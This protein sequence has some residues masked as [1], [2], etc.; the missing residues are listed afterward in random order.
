MS[1]E[2]YPNM[3][4]KS[5]RVS[6]KGRFLCSDMEAVGLLDA[7]R[8]NDPTCLHTF[9]I[10]DMFT[11][12]KFLFFDPYEKRMEHSRLA[13]EHDGHQDGYL[14]DAIQMLMEAEAICFQ[15]GVGYDMLAL[16][17]VYPNDWKFN[18][19]EARGKDREHSA[20]FPR[21]L[22]DTMIISQLLNP[23]RRA[24]PQAFALGR[25]NVGPHSI[26]AHGI[27]IGRYKPENED[28][29]VLTDHMLHRVEEDT[30]IGMDFFYWLMNNEWADSVRRGR[31]RV[32]GL[33]IASAYA[34][35]LQVA[36]S[37]ARQGQRGFRLDTNRAW[38][39]WVEI[40]E[41]MDIIFNKI[42]P[43]I[44]KR[45][46]TDPMKMSHITARCNSFSKAFKAEGNA[47]LGSLLK[48]HLLTPDARIGDKMPVWE[49]T[50]KSGDYSAAVKKYYPEMVG[51]IND[52]KNPLV[53]GAFTPLIWE[54]IGLG[55]LDYI[56]EHVLYPHGWS[57]VTYSDSEQ[58]WI[59][60][61]KENPSGEPLNPWSGKIDELSLAA[62]RAREEVPEFFTDIVKWYVL[63]SRR[64]QILNVKDMQY[65]EK[66]R[67]F[68]NQKNGKSYC[69]GLLAKAFSKEHNVEAWQYF[70]NT[71]EYPSSLDEEWRVPAE[72]F[73]IGT[74]TFRM[75]H[76]HVVNIPARGLRPLRHLFI[77]GI[78]KAI[79]G[80]D[81]AGLELRM[82]A[83]FM[84]DAIYTEVVLNGDIH[85]YNQEL[86]GLPYRDMAKTFIYA[87]LYG[88]GVK[89]LAKVCGLTESE[90]KERVE[91]FR[92]ELPSLS[93]LIAACEKAGEKYGYLQAIDGRWGRIRKS[94][95]RLSIHTVLN[96]L[97]QMT[98]SLCM[99]YGLCLA[100]RQMLKEGVALDEYGFPMF[101]A[102]VH[103][104]VQMEVDINEVQ[105][106]QYELS[107]LEWKAEE[108]RVHVVDGKLW[109][110]PS[111]I[112]GDK[113]GT[114]P[115]LIGRS[116]HR[117]GEILSRTMEETGELLKLRIPLAGEYKIG[118]SWAETH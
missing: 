38:K 12:E 8:Y 3:L 45:L 52:T 5:E 13:L 1:L 93:N 25:G 42:N 27:R 74:N 33:G 35:E 80:C 68:P 94:G 24:P 83:H 101:V 40:G 60:N 71:G 76:K 2:Y 110:A 91:R 118:A 73:S 111:I 31:N 57:G 34:M 99:K 22:M 65:F 114:E 115:L 66:N 20:Y 98:G 50:K 116:Y 55:N 96:V 63:R 87:F 75:R 47:W 36:L 77:A 72:A 78:G 6:G 85:T 103:D 37:I 92:T 90:M 19:L 16:E 107:P 95:G 7:I 29:S 69:K 10:I 18:Y 11:Q 54:E 113:K 70:L 117:A 89:N 97:L 100:E 112:S 48:S 105:H 39:D 51:N 14:I 67:H 28:W 53:A 15:N 32:S 46:S 41:E 79:V 86:A 30:Y 61:Y 82:L 84:N 4:P 108:K 21:K 49:L 88:S 26:E 43:H 59:E 64:S 56:K 23:D 58:K 104:E 9:S 106:I 62:W 44:P 109:S 102:N 17:K 81:G